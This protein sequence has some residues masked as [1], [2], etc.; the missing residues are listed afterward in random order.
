[1]RVVAGEAKGRILKSPRGLETRPATNKIKEAIFDIL[2][3]RTKDAY[4]LDLFA[5]SG[6]LGIEALSR[7]ARE[8]IFVDVSPQATDTIKKNLKTLRWEPRAKV[9]CVKSGA[10]IKNLADRK[11]RFDIIFSDPPYSQRIST[12]ILEEL[13]TSDM[14]AVEGVVVTRFR[15]DEE[16]PDTVARFRAIVRKT[17]GDSKVVFW[18][19]SPEEK[20]S[21]I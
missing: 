14:L 8:T 1:M 18:T 21:Y 2:G 16:V 7:G 4:V 12:Q 15:K 10:A 3:P 5:G 20:K 19:A 6:S 17:Y 9:L 11:Q 13:S